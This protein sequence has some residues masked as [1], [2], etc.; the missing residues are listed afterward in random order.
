MSPKKPEN[1]EALELE[2]KKSTSKTPGLLKKGGLA[3]NR[4]NTAPDKPATSWRSC[5][6]VPIVE[7]CTQI[8]NIPSVNALLI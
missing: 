2:R 7:L 1:F 4:K 8:V 3:L 6:L 5:E